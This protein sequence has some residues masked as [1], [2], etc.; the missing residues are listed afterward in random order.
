MESIPSSPPATLAEQVAAAQ[1]WWRDAGVDC[2]FV[3]EP[4]GWLHDTVGTAAAP[5]PATPIIAAPRPVK[6]DQPAV[7]LGGDEAGWPTDLPTFR[8]WWLTEPTL[9]VGGLN[10]RIPPRGE[11]G[12]PLMV[13]VP[14][15]E[16]DDGETLLSGREGRLLANFALAAGIN[17]AALHVASALPRHMVAPDWAALAAG[18]L[19][20]ILRHH[21]Q[22]AAPKRLLVMGRDILPL[23]GHDP[24]QSTPGPG[25]LRLEGQELPMLATYAPARLLDHARLRTAL[26]RHWLDWTDGTA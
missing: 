8:E 14:M 26:W 3:D 11:A 6:P 19:G 20:Q 7:R 1:Q 21:I 15:P 24:A 10:A 5:T 17:P 9:D 25:N 13:L 2:L 23:I 22:L 4:Q 12:A 18:G 16:A